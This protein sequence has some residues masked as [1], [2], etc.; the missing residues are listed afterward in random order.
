MAPRRP[1]LSGPY[2]GGLSVLGLIGLWVAVT[3]WRALPSAVDYDPTVLPM[4]V[5]GAALLALALMWKSPW[6][7]MTALVGLAAAGQASAL[8][9]IDAPRYAIYQHYVPWSR[10]LEA[11]TLVLGIL[12][13][14]AIV[15]IVLAVRTWPTVSTHARSV[16]RSL[17]GSGPRGLLLTLGVLGLLAF[18]IVVPTESAARAVGEF[19]LAAWVILIGLL[20]LLL[21]AGVAPAEPLRRTVAWLDHHVTLDATR[22]ELRP[23]DR[24]LPWGV[25]AWV[26][27]VTALVSWFV[28]EG[29]PHIDDSIS[30]LFQAK[31]LSTG[32]LFLPAPPDSASFH[33][34]ETIV[35]G[36]RWFG[37]AF[38]GWP[39]VLALGALVGLPWLVNPLIAGLTVL[40]AHRVVR[41][42]VRSEHCQPLGMPLG[43]LSMVRFH[44]FV[45]HG[46]YRGPG[47]RP[48]DAPRGRTRATAS[49]CRMGAGGG[50]GYRRA[51]SDAPDRGDVRG[52][53]RIALDGRVERVSRAR[54]LHAGVRRVG[55]W[56]GS[57]CVRL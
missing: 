32:Q 6:R 55:G 33:V 15:C 29:V 56:R 45:V 40:V 30:Y 19:A 28:M 46:A 24:S 49:H 38:P 21:V 12:T 22:E 18:A 54:A 31:Y 13:I 7:S 26:V 10:L 14:Q 36:P 43:S 11:P 53:H 3:R 57:H 52:E 20:N 44:I 51:V 39:A 50:R 16:A 48:L 8:Q 47:L 4:L 2:R 35:D 1:A 41:L 9:L 5:S 42:I 27:V 17:L 37:Y 25:A 34:A 23:W